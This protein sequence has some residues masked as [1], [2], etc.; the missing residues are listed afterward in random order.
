[1]TYNTLKQQLEDSKELKEFYKNIKRTHYLKICFFVILN[2]L[3]MS[4]SLLSVLS[5]EIYAIYSFLLSVVLV[6]YNYKL[7]KDYKKI[8]LRIKK[9]TRK[10]TETKN[11]LFIF[12]EFQKQQ[13][14]QRT[15]IHNITKQEKLSNAYKLLKLKNDDTIDKIKSTYRKLAIKWHPD[16][17]YTSSDENKSIAD[18]N[19]RKLN[20]A[21]DLIKEDMNII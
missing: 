14:Q 19:F 7:I 21:Y 2:V 6:I 18:R 1:M 13:Q 20:N 5:G 9:L 12:R 15:Y 4:L 8:K 3:L 16:K 17:W 10:I 11:F